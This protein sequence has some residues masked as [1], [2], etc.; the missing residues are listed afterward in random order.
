MGLGSGEMATATTTRSVDQIGKTAGLVWHLLD[1][2]G[3]MSLAQLAKQMDA[4]RD[5]VM[6][7]VGWLARE[8]KVVIEE[9]NRARIIRLK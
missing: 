7:A 4:P 5:S 1:E 2:N 3:A 8:D 6:Q 9:K